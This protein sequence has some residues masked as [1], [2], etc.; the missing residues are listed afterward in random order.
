[1]DAAAAESRA[2]SR[3]MSSIRQ[4]GL[5]A[6]RQRNRGAEKSR[7]GKGRQDTTSATFK[8]DGGARQSCERWLQA[9]QSCPTRR[10][11]QRARRRQRARRPCLD[12]SLLALLAVSGLHTDIAMYSGRHGCQSEML[13]TIHSCSLL[14]RPHPARQKMVGKAGVRPSAKAWKRLLEAAGPTAARHMGQVRSRSSHSPRQS[15]QKMWLQESLTGSRYASWRHERAAAVR[16]VESGGA[17]QQ[18]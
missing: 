8:H 16:A 17:V 11:A 3:S 4:S 9:R 14:Y 2:R 18:R 10:A 5:W 7:G 1:M 13:C 15:W 12:A 6:S